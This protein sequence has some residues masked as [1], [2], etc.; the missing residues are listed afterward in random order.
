[1]KRTIRR[2]CGPD[3]FRLHNLAIQLRENNDFRN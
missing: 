1:M 3:S 2:L